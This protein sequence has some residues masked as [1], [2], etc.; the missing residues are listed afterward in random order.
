MDPTESSSS[1]RWRRLAV[2]LVGLTCKFL[3]PRSR[4]PIYEWARENIV[5]PDVEGAYA[6]KPYDIARSPILREILDWWQ[7]ESLPGRSVPHKLVLMKGS[8][9]GVTLVAGIATA[10]DFAND[11]GSV[12]YISN[13]ADQASKTGRFRFV[14]LIAQADP[15]A[16]G[17]IEEM[18]EGAV[19][20]LIKGHLFLC[21]GGQVPSALVSWP[22]R[23]AIVDESA[24]HKCSDKGST[25]ELAEKRTE[26]QPGRKVF[27]FS[28]P[29]GWPI[30]RADP[31]NRTLQ[32]VSG[33]DTIFSDAWLSGTQEVPMVPCPH[34]GKY[35]ELTDEQFRAPKN[36]LPGLDLPESGLDLIQIEQNTWYE[37]LHCL[38]PIYDEKHKAEM[39]AAYRMEAPPL[40]EKEARTRGFAKPRRVACDPAHPDIVLYRRP[41][42]GVRSIHISDFYN[43]ASAECNWGI[44]HRKKIVAQ[45][46]LEKFAIYCKDTR[47]L[48]PPEVS[49]S[50]DLT[51]HVLLRLC[52]PFER[53]RILDENGILQGPQHPLPCRVHKLMLTVDYQQGAVHQSSYF[54]FLITAFDEKRQPWF[55]DWGIARNLEMLEDIM[56]LEFTTPDGLKGAIQFGLMDSQH[57][58]TTVIEFCMRPGIYGRLWPSAGVSKNLDIDRRNLTEKYGFLYWVYNY[59]NAYW[60]AKLYQWALGK[61]C[62]F[63]NPKTPGGLH[64]DQCRRHAALCPRPFFPKDA[65]TEFL[66]QMSNMHQALVDENDP[67]KGLIW[68]KVH[69]SKPNDYGDA[70]KL[71]LIARRIFFP[72]PASAEEAPPPPAPDGIAA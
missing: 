14:P 56:K 28:K 24:L 1:G 30:Y 37:C 42:P 25:I 8:Q 39:V 50:V 26:K 34:C 16:A 20:K 49:R 60:E 53:L 58:P 6:G 62:E 55:C 19:Y 11:P 52:A 32:R 71:A 51:P 64:T 48:P 40:D 69:P 67:S 70:A 23:K 2:I 9:S 29:E 17:D 66:E 5:L 3:R 36:L 31:R 22:I 61:W 72:R 7:A 43:V 15:E 4:A 47:G 45:R 46:S 18:G 33:D 59:Q 54:P 13:N 21:V 38:H 65:D 63:L 10:H 12:L 35:Q 27:V 68:K 57:D 44:L 41:D